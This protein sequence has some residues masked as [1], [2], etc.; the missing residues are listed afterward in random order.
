MSQVPSTIFDSHMIPY[1]WLV[2]DTCSLIMIQI[3]SKFIINFFKH[4]KNSHTF[5]TYDSHVTF[6]FYIISNFHFFYKSFL[7]LILLL[8]FPHLWLIVF[9][10]SPICVWLFWVISF[11]QVLINNLAHTSFLLLSYISSFLFLN[12]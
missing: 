8:V 3:R 1:L 7:Q 6:M 5:P 12:L 4:K 11:P 10:Y 2:C 9:L